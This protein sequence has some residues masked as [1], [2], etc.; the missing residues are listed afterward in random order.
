MNKYSSVRFTPIAVGKDKIKIG[1][2]L[3]NFH[4]DRNKGIREILLFSI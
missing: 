3:V 4:N 1:G 2:D